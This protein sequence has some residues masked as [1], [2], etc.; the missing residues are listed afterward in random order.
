MKFKVIM[1]ILNTIVSKR[2]MTFK[3]EKIVKKT[4][5]KWNL[6]YIEFCG[7]LNF[8]PLNQI[9]FTLLFKKSQPPWWPNSCY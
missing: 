2:I 9:Q 1:Q 6:V 4:K 5:T 8:T 7:N 3:E